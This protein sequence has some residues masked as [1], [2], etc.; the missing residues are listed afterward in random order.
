MASFLGKMSGL[1]SN[2]GQWS[3]V[4]AGQG[5]A[6]MM[7]QTPPA[8]LKIAHVKPCPSSLGIS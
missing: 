5:R 3:A 2:P 1:A 6:V 4:E 8:D 7:H